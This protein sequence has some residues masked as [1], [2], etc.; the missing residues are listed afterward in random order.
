MLIKSSIVKLDLI[1]INT[2]IYTS[3]MKSSRA[4]GAGRAMDRRKQADSTQGFTSK[5]GDDNNMV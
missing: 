5:Y 3:K 1:P 4:T 2:S